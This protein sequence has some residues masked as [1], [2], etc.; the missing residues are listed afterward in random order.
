MKRRADRAGGTTP[1][2]RVPAREPAAGSLL[3]VAA[4]VSLVLGEST[5]AAIILVIVVMSVG[6]GFFNEYRSLQVVAELDKRLRRTAIALRDGRASVVD[7]AP[8]V[9]GD[10][11]AVRLGDIVPADVRILDAQGLERDESILT[12]EA[13]P[14]PKD[15][16]PASG[17]G[18]PLELSSC[19]FF[20]TVVR[21][22][23]AHGVVVRTGRDTEF[24]TIAARVGTRLPETAFQR[25]LRG[26]IG[27]LVRITAVVVVLVVVVDTVLRHSFFETLLFALG[28]AVSLTPQLLPAIVTV[29]LATGALRMAARNVLVKRLVSSPLRMASS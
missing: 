4:V 19:A 15:A 18:G 10:V 5:D 14:A 13:V 27:L 21:A 6:L 12:G 9:P 16:R 23:T 8:L 1:R 3:A 11:I 28:I 7:A 22:G 25:G 2:S 26:V 29:S 20:G 17:T 24:G